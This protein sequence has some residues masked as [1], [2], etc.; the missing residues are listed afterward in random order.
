M[1][2]E[3]GH[4]ATYGRRPCCQHIQRACLMSR[5]IFCGGSREWVYIYACRTVLKRNAS[6]I[7]V[8]PVQRPFPTYFRR[9]RNQTDSRTD[10]WGAWSCSSSSCCSSPSRVRQCCHRRSPRRSPPPPP[11]LPFWK[12]KPGLA[13]GRSQPGSGCSGGETASGGKDDDG[14][15][16]RLWQ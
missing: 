10:I 13:F 6:F 1:Q 5:H 11:S 2:S 3:G 12:E 7:R 9:L 14:S 4:E 16:K 8:Y 15:A